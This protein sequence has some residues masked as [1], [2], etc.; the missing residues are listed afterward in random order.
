MAKNFL[1]VFDYLF[2]NYVNNTKKFPS[3]DERAHLETYAGQAV[4]RARDKFDDN[5]D[6][7]SPEEILNSM[8]EEIIEEMPKPMAEIKSLPLKDSV[9][10]EQALRKKLEGQQQQA[11]EGIM[12][13]KDRTDK[14]A[15]GLAGLLGV[16]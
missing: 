1:K 6:E 5:I 10:R 11:R 12:S 9:R 14:A 2:K 15:G 16:E 13:L 8:Q 4:M 3:L 7:L